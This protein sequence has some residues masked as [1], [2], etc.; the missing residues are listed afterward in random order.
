[1]D[2]PLSNLDANLRAQMRTEIASRRHATQ[3]V[4]RLS[5]DS[6]AREGRPVML[7][8]DPARLHVFDPETGRR[9]IDEP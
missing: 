2:E 3:L 8:F 4:A 9:L 6:Q 7:W 1:M 5:V